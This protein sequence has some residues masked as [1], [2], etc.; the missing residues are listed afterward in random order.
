MEIKDSRSQLFVKTG[1]DVSKIMDNEN[2][3]N[4]NH[5]VCIVQTETALRTSTVFI[6][7]FFST[8]ALI[9]IYI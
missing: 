5:I 1:C 4:C 8:A 9:Y 7:S 2:K 6:L 3:I